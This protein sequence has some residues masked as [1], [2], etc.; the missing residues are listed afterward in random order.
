MCRPSI[1]LAWARCWAWRLSWVLVLGLLG[2]GS[3]AHKSEVSHS[4]TRPP[5]PGESVTPPPAVPATP[6]R[7]FDPYATAFGVCP[8]SDHENYALHCLDGRDGEVYRCSLAFHV[9]FGVM[10]DSP[11]L[12]WPSDIGS[13]GGGGDRSSGA[14]FFGGGIGAAILLPVMKLILKKTGLS[15]G[16]LDSVF[17]GDFGL[18]VGTMCEMAPGF[19]DLMCNNDFVGTF[20]D[21][22]ERGGAAILDLVKNKTKAGQIVGDLQGILQGKLKG[23][24][25]LTTVDEAFAMGEAKKTAATEEEH[26]EESIEEFDTFVERVLPD[27]IDFAY[28]A[29]GTGFK[30]V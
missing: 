8:T 19:A 6:E 4:H 30:R 27:C 29:E 22:K 16:I 5:P 14:R 25:G 24:L 3:Q 11:P 2:S 1:W 10:A 12:A 18:D 13:G 15:S 20:K 21:V 23:K 9:T 26:V 17:S 28:D 7:C